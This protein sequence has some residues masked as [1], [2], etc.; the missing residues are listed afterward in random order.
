M[1][2]L[3][4]NRGTDSSA[5]L[6]KVADPY[7]TA[8]EASPDTRADDSKRNAVRAVHR[9]L[10][11]RY[12][13]VIGLSIVLGGLGAYFGYRRG[14]LIYT[15]SG[16]VRVNYT[17]QRVLYPDDETGVL[18]GFDAF[19]EAQATALVGRKVI[20]MAVTEPQWVAVHPAPPTDSTVVELMRR[21]K[22][23]RKTDV[24]QVEFS[25]IDPSVAT[26]A[27]NSVI[28]AYRKLYIDRDLETGDRRLQVLKDMQTALLQEAAT[29]RQKMMAIANQ[30]GSE[31][32][33]PIY[34]AKLDQFNKIEATIQELE[35]AISGSV[36][37]K[38]PLAGMSDRALS[39]VDTR[40]SVLHDKLSDAKLEL[41]V[42]L[43]RGL[44]PELPQVQQ[45]Q[46]LVKGI[47]EQIEARV[48]D[49][50]EM[51]TDGVGLSGL[52]RGVGSDLE[53]MKARL[54]VLQ[55]RR[56]QLW[57]E[58]LGI[59]QQNLQ[60]S[61]LRAEADSVK[62]KLDDVRRR[63]EELHV[64]KP[65]SRRVEVLSEGEAPLVPDKDTRPRYAAAGG[66]GG[67]MLATCM[68]MVVGLIKRGLADPQDLQISLGLKPV[69]G[70]IPTLADGPDYVRRAG[71]AADCVH[72]TRTML[73]IWGQRS[74]QLVVG[75][76][77]PSRGA[78]KTSIAMSLGVSFA[79]A[80]V[81]TLLI[82]CDFVGG[83]LTTRLQAVV[84]RDIVSVLRRTR[85][86]SE[87]QIHHATRVAAQA[88]TTGQAGA[89]SLGEVCV[90]LGYL[91]EAE[92]KAAQALQAEDG[93][94]VLDA[95]AGEPLQAC[96]G[97]TGIPDLSVLPLGR[98]TPAHAAKVSTHALR[99]VLDG[100][101]Q[102]FDV[103]LVD[104]S[105]VP[106]GLEASVVASA[107][108]GMIVT[109]AR[110]EQGPRVTECLE[111]LQTLCCPLAGIV[112]NQARL[113]DV[114]SVT[115]FDRERTH[116]TDLVGADDAEVLPQVEPAGRLA[117]LGL[118]ARAVVSCVPA[119][120]EGATQSQ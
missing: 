11:G 89:R 118:L 83:G 8:L 69:L 55:P 119:T 59:G 6:V 74:K 33:D 52:N 56:E 57:K 30:Y 48:A 40:L 75:V 7:D 61:D 27:V 106:G 16:A 79:T 2:R 17:I 41:S 53:S 9:L 102:H 73:E 108:D 77:S 18:P 24:L 26:A 91:S 93:V 84:R 113:G 87:A 20:E 58:L 44:Q 21:L 28:D 36:S 14:A 66:L 47:E 37:G 103:I 81:R 1:I 45:A 62:Q 35:L 10:R 92:L 70:V 76:T 120:Q 23:T 68:V 64:E 31:H 115:A 39:F 50:R 13:W 88:A 85:L 112:F 99:Q 90:D 98:A 51:A 3:L 94:G 5:G 67:I 49:L 114:P 117:T 100:A 86:V 15:S 72:H 97:K 80:G 65:S 60:L 25:D 42:L 54:S 82:D 110:G 12:R 111:R 38:T 109:V 4:P 107:V 101:R 29:N 63:I 43:S 71:I 19:V 78:G 32:I 104:T 34:A 105:S 46:A 95:L 22:V 116:R 96:I